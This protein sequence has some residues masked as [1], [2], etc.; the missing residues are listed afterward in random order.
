M[1]R[2]FENCDSFIVGTIGNPG[3]REFYFQAKANGEVL[4]F[5]CEKAQAQALADRFVLLLKDL[6]SRGIDTN[7]F[8]LP[9]LIVPLISEIEIEEIS[10]SW[11]LEL[12]KISLVLADAENEY[13][14]F[15]SPNIAAS[16]I[17]LM[18][19]VSAAG[20]ALCPFCSLPINLDGHLCPRANGYRR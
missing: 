18:K 17:E 2:R 16:F 3:E 6:K 1:K 11:N 9:N 8:E 12:K 5:A 15:F 10:I 4:S 13:E 20:R 19:E 7:R 14:L